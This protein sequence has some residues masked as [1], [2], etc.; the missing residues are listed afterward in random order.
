MLRNAICELRG[1]YDKHRGMLVFKCHMVSF[2]KLLETFNFSAE[3]KLYLF[4]STYDTVV[5]N[6]FFADNIF[7]HIQTQGTTDK[8]LKFLSGLYL[9]NS[10][11]I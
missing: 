9:T 4:E 11:F 2:C 7:K 1:I 8:I 5:Q 10:F 6:Y 3:I